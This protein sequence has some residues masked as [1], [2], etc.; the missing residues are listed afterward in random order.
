MNR[1]N[2]FWSV[3]VEWILIKICNIQVKQSCSRKFS[4]AFEKG[5]WNNRQIHYR[6]TLTFVKQGL[7]FFSY[8]VYGIAYVYLHLLLHWVSCTYQDIQGENDLSQTSVILRG[9]I[10]LWINWYMIL[11]WISEETCIEKDCEKS[12][13]RESKNVKRWKKLGQTI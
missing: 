12:S 4:E 3:T 2:L 10:S 1:D 13:K 11:I 9:K 7:D 6:Q 8:K 5:R